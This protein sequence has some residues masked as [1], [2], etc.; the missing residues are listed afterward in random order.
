MSIAK[1]YKQTEVGVIPKDWEVKRIGDIVSISIGRDLKEAHFSNYQDSKFAYPIYSNTVSN[2]G[3]YGYYDF[4][5][6][7]GESITIVGRGVGLGKAFSRKGGYGAIGRLL[8]LFPVYDINCNYL[9]EYINHRVK[10]FS[11]SGGIPQLTG[12]TLVKYQI[13]L[14]PLPEQTAIA[15]ALSDMD[16]LIS[17]TE[18]LIEKKKSIKQGMMQELL[19]GRTRIQGFGDQKGY[20]QT[21]VGVIPEDWEVKNIGEIFEFHTTSNFSK[22]QMSLDG[23]V[24]CLHYG[25]IHAIPTS[26]YDVKYG[27]KYFINENLAKYEFIVDGDIVMVDASE[28]LDG[29]NKSVEISGIGTRKCISGLHTFLLR[30]KGYLANYFRGAILNSNIVKNQMVRLAVGMKVYG[31]SKPQLKTV[32]IPLPP[33]PEQTAIASALSDMDQEISV[34]ESKLQKLKLQKQGMMQALLTGKIRLI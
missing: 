24:G 23:E 26:S 7:F 28:D 31:V 13:P 25:L 33:L 29:L 14:P 21:E 18:K 17:H 16:A 5:E 10:I 22:A 9:T 4:A 2:F 20:K 34:H 1:G 6:Y 3:L 30:D 19:T 11:E 12:V 8:V 27:I 32:N 15:S